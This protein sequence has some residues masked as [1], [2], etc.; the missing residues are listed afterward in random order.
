MTDNFLLYDSGASNKRILIF[1]TM[2]NLRHMEN[3]TE[4]FSDGT[5]KVAPLLFD[6]LYTIHVLR[7]QKVIPMVYALLPNRLETTY[8]K[9]L[10]A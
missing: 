4:W 3:S 2:K 9:M 10:T 8:V 1:G 5:F 6:Q 7:F